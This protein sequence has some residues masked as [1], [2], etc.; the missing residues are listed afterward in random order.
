MCNVALRKSVS[1]ICPCAKV[2]Q[3]SVSPELSWHFGIAFH[4]CQSQDVL[5]SLVFRGAT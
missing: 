2:Q 5:G 3:F 4:S 1:F